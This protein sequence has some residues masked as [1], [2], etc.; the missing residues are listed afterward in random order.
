[1]R[2]FVHRIFTA[3][4]IVLP[5]FSVMGQDLDDLY[6]RVKI[7][8]RAPEFRV[9]LMIT[10]GVPVMLSNRIQREAFRGLIASDLLVNIKTAKGFHVGI[11]GQYAAFQTRNPND[12]KIKNRDMVQHHITPGI[13][14]GYEFRFKKDQRFSFYPSLF[15]GYGF[16]YISG[17]RNGLDTV[18]YPGA[19]NTFLAQGFMVSPQVSFFMHMGEDLQSTIGFFLA[20]NVF[21]YEMKKT[22]IY[23]EK[24]VNGVPVTD[25]SY[26]INV[27]DNGLTT[28]LKI[29]FVFMQRFKKLRPRINNQP[30]L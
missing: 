5:A 23:L 15:G 28:Y 30:D 26:F 1:M 27:P 4:L 12:F 25:D 7:P 8:D 19:K 16:N 6:D 13:S 17:L 24:M 18:F 9:N 11:G 10:P 22:H 3:I 21:G 29:G 14:L 20:A 2:F